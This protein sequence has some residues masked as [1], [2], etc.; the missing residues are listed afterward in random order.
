[1]DNY[2]QNN[3]WNP[4]FQDFSLLN[5]NRLYLTIPFI[6]RGIYA[7]AFLGFRI[8]PIEMGV[9]KSD[10][11][12]RSNK[13]LSRFGHPF[14]CSLVGYRLYDQKNRFFDR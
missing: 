3:R 8:S 11:S 13:G 1:M 6:H 5:P 10:N 7:N 4:E 12:V 14:G 2:L 9:Q